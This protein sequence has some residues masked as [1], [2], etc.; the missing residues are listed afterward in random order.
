MFVA[1]GFIYFQI[2]RILPPP[3]RKPHGGFMSFLSAVSLTPES[4]TRKAAVKAK[5]RAEGAGGKG[6]KTGGGAVQILRNSQTRRASTP[7]M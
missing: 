1:Q 2:R 4:G 3:G 6:E 5:P 7:R